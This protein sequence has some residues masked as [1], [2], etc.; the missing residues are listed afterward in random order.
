M[1]LIFAKFGND[2]YY[3]ATVNFFLCH[4]LKMF[5]RERFSIL[6]GTPLLRLKLRLFAVLD[7]RLSRA[8]LRPE[9][10][11]RLNYAMGTRVGIWE[12]GS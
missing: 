4:K 5:L 9:F 3:F 6:E 2:C 10:M 11:K 8:E 12:K 1:I 7:E